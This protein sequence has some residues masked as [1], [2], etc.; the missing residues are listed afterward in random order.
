MDKVADVIKSKVSNCYVL[1]DPDSTTASDV[2]KLKS[3]GNR[4]GCYMS[5]GSIEQER[6]DFKDFK[7]GQDYD[8]KLP[9]WEKEYMLLGDSSGKPTANTVSLM[10]KRIDNMANLKCD[11][12]EFDNMDFT[13]DDQIIKK[14]KLTKDGIRAYNKDLCNYMKSKNI[15]CMYKNSGPSDPDAALWDGLT[16]ESNKSAPVKID[17]SLLKKFTDNGEPLYIS[18]Y[19]EAN[20]A[21]CDGVFKKFKSDYKDKVA[22]VCSVY[23]GKQNTYLHYP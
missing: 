10:K 15:K 6:K 2:A 8:S 23:D 14:Q 19:A 3:A 12:I 4:V 22:M 20:K 16:F 21:G 9:N 11:F 7:K 13:G 18:H 5:V 17:S 1:V